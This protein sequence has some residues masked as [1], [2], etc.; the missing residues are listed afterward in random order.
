MRIASN[1]VNFN[2]KVTMDLRCKKYYKQS[3]EFRETVNAIESDVEADEVCLTS[4][5]NRHWSGTREI[6]AQS[7]HKN[8]EIQDYHLGTVDEGTYDRSGKISFNDGFKESS[9]IFKTPGDYYN[10]YVYHKK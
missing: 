7:E 10:V 3:P 5:R 2:A 1:P 8:G 4:D 6:Y 9:G